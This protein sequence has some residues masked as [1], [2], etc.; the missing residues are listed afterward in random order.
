MDANASWKRN[1]RRGNYAL[2][3]GLLVWIVVGFA[4]FS[5]DIAL[6]TMA[7][8]QAQAAADAASHA[9]L[10]AFRENFVV[11][12]GNLAANFIMEMDKVA[13]GT[14]VIEPGF[15]QYGQYDFDVHAFNPGLTAMGSANAVRVRV[16]RKGPT[17][18]VELLLAPMYPINKPT[19]DVIAESITSQQMRAIEV[20]VDMSCSM[21]GSSSTSAVNISRL[22]NLGFLD[23]LV[24]HPQEGDMLGITMFAQQAATKPSAAAPGGGRSNVGTSIPWLPVGYI[25]SNE[26][27]MRDRINGICNTANKSQDPT[28][29]CPAGWHPVVKTIGS[30]TNGEP[31][32]KQAI[33]QLKTYTDTTYFRGLIFFSDGEPNCD[34]SGAWDEV[35]AMNR[36]YAQATAAW[37]EDISVWTILFHNG[38]FDPAFMSNMVRGIGFAQ[39]SPNAA[40][41]P[42]MYQQVA[43]SL[44]TALV[45]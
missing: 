3:M 29:L 22:A 34:A 39:I 5:V 18:A 10:V 7:E 40:D 14:A 9:A 37:N 27:E 36:S 13:M 38:W 44:P 12:E 8:L 6:I 43:K 41:L 11:A 33:Y 21:M 4:A 30:C 23:Y 32:L 31:A 2:L 25:E 24:S 20:V 1:E 28:A 26:E 19:H 35:G 45:Y 42:A 17:N 15:P 16:S